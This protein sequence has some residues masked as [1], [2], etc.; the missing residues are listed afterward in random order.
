MKHKKG[1]QPRPR[2]TLLG[3]LGLALV[4][5]LALAIWGDVSSRKGSTLSGGGQP[6]SQP[7][8]NP[9]P[10]AAPAAQIPPYFDSAE[11]A[12]PFPTLLSPELFRNHALVTRAY[13]IAAQITGVLA[14]QPCY[15]HCDKFGHRSLLD[16]YSSQHG[17][18]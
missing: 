17:A 9:A 10:V 18:G 12:M 7:E 15:C 5:A 2:K 1:K 3:V 11:A 8:S 16:C 4:V 6:V 13:E 14:Q